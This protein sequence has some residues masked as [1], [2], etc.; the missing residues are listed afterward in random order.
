MV[1][2]NHMSTP[3]S[4]AKRIQGLNS[5]QQKITLA[6]VTKVYD[7]NQLVISR[8][9][10]NSNKGTAVGCTVIATKRNQHHTD[11]GM[12]PSLMLAP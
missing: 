5:A 2:T 6:D 10:P 11:S 1:R 8:S 9:N 12:Q 4:H 7:T 3:C